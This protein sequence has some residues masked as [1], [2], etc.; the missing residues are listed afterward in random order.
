MM[1]ISSDSTEPLLQFPDVGLSLVEAIALEAPAGSIDQGQV[2][3]PT[4][5]PRNF[6]L[7]LSP[8]SSFE[9]EI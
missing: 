9:D 2:S 8:I 7:D 3:R 5:T 4:E 1:I 6:V